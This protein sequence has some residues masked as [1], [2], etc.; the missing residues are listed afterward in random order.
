M[1]NATTK[2]KIITAAILEAVTSGNGGWIKGIL[3]AVEATKVTKTMN[4]YTLRSCLQGLLDSEQICRAAFN[5]K[6][7]DEY[8]VLPGTPGAR[9]EKELQAKYE[10]DY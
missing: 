10:G 1:M 6:A 3:P 8:Y 9:N 7:D 2:K 5:P 4:A